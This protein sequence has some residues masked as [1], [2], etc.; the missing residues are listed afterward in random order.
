MKPVGLDWTTRQESL[1][2]AAK[3]TKVAHRKPCSLQPRVSWPLKNLIIR[4]SKGRTE[5]LW[6]LDTCGSSVSQPLKN[7][8]FTPPTCRTEALLILWLE[9]LMLLRY[10]SLVNG[11]TKNAFTKSM[12]LWQGFH[13]VQWIGFLGHKNSVYVLAV[14]QVTLSR[15]PQ[16]A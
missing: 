9:G 14:S 12:Y 16:D 5:A 2:Q 6:M 3:M 4:P 13:D 10:P 11:I 8:T 15:R 7:L 1:V